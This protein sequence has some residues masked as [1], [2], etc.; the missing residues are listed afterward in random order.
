ML[1]DYYGGVVQF[2]FK[3]EQPA[4]KMME[5]NKETIEEINKENTNQDILE[6]SKN[7]NW[8]KHRFR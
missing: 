3:W 7:G 5:G 1:V 2:L 4:P 8:P 6:D